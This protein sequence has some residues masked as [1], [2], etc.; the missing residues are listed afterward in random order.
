MTDL[1]TYVARVKQLSAAVC[2]AHDLPHLQRTASASAPEARSSLFRISEDGIPHPCQDDYSETLHLLEQKYGQYTA[3]FVAN[4]SS[5]THLSDSERHTLVGSGVAALVLLPLRCGERE[6]GLWQ[7]SWDEP[8]T[9]TT[10]DREMWHAY[11]SLLAPAFAY[12]CR[13]QTLQEI[14]AAHERDLDSHRGET[15]RLKALVET[16]SD[17][18]GYADLEG[19]VEYLNPASDQLLGITEDN[20][21]HFVHVSDIYSDASNAFF[22]Q[23][24]LPQLL[25][26]GTWR[27]EAT[28]RRADGSE[29]PVSQVITVIPDNNGEPAALGTVVR[30]I[31]ESKAL[32]A[33]LRRSNALHTRLGDLSQALNRVSNKRELL[34][35]IGQVAF[36]EAAT[37]VTLFDVDVQTMSDQRPDTLEAAVVLT[38]AGEN[39]EPSASQTI[40]LADFPAARL[41]LETPDDILLVSD[42]QT[43][44]RIDEA[45]RQLFAA[46]DSRAQ[47]I[48]PLL[49]N[50]QWMGVVGIAWNEPHD[51]LPREV[52]S[53]DALRNM[54]PP[55]LA[56]LNIVAD[57]ETLVAER[58]AELQA[59]NEQLELINWVSTRLKTTSSNGETLDILLEPLSKDAKASLWYV[60][61]DQKGRRLGAYLHASR[62]DIGVP[63]G[64]YVAD[65]DYPGAN[66][67]RDNPN[68]TIFIENTQT[69]TRV[70]EAS[71]D[72]FHKSDVA[73][74]AAIPLAE[75]QGW[76]G[77]LYVN[78]VLPRTF[79]QREQAYLAALP[80]IL[81][82]TLANRRLV[83]TLEETVDARTREL[84]QQLAKTERFK[85]LIESTTDAV[86]YADLDGTLHSLNVAGLAMFGDDA[87]EVYHNIAEMFVA[88]D[89]NFS[90]R[91]MPSL[92]EKG[93]WQGEVLAKRT[94]GSHLPT[95]EVV[96]VIRDPDGQPVALGAVIRDI[97]ASKA[98]EADLRQS[99]AT[100]RRIS[101]LSQAVNQV[102][103]K[104]QLHETITDTVRDIGATSVTLF[105]VDTLIT[106]G[107]P[108]SLSV[109][110]LWR[111]DGSNLLLVGTSF[112]L[113]DYPSASL[114]LEQPD[115]P[116]AV[117]DITTDPRLDDASKRTF[118]DFGTAAN[119]ILVLRQS[120]QWVGVLSIGWDE[121]HSYSDEENQLYDALQNIL[122][123]VLAN[124]NIVAD[125][126]N[127]VAERSAELSASN[128]QLA[129]INQV[130]SELKAANST[131]VMLDVLLEPLERSAS[132]SLFY[133]ITND[134]GDMQAIQIAAERTA[135]VAV[136]VGTVF[137]V[138]NYPV[139]Q[140]WLN[141]PNAAL[142]IEDLAHD[143]RIDEASRGAL[144]QFGAASAIV[145]LRQSGEWVGVLLISYRE[146]YTFSAQERAYFNALPT[147]L[148]P[149][150][151]NRRLVETLEETID[152]RTRELRQSRKL[153]LATIDNAP[154]IISVKD[155]DLRY[156]LANGN[157]DQLVPGSTPNSIIGKR[158]DAL[159][160]ADMAA[161]ITRSDEQVM[162]DKR[163]RTYQ[164]T[165]TNGRF[166]DVNKFPLLDKDGNVFAIGMVAS[167]I[168]EK[169]RKSVEMQ[170]YREQ[171]AK[172]ET[173]LHIT[174]RIQ[175]LLLPAGAELEDIHDLD[176]A[177]YVQ[178]AEQVGGDYYDVL[179]IGD[180][181]KIGIGDVTG[182]GLESGLL[183]LMTQT[184]VR[185]LMSTDEHDPVRIMNILNQTVFD[186]LQ[187]MN[188]NKSLTL[189]LLDYQ[190]GEAGGQLRV[191]GQHEHVLV[192]R[193]DGRVDVIDTLDLGMPLGLEADI[194]SFVAEEVIDLAIGEGVIL[195]TDG[196]TEAENDKREQFGLERLVTL[197]THHWQAPAQA[198]CDAVIS[199]VYDYIGD[200]EIYDDIT[201]LVF[202]RDAPLPLS[203]A[204]QPR[205]LAND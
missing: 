152:K 76:V 75:A 138:D 13:E 94:D 29:L 2:T 104:R 154:L 156:I 38:P 111:A 166:Y 69:D 188:T 158:D 130:S 21:A 60:K 55:A 15:L 83:E 26:T 39:T 196:I 191:S 23:H 195:F 201:L 163:T 73:A 51:F 115:V 98:L 161:D 117:S 186:N 177:C 32:E 59:S 36:D 61:N 67:H 11:A 22:E 109:A 66:L 79:S 45:S 203:S 118:A 171:L 9:L 31:S 90:D 187:R 96:T 62:P 112:P 200:H 144:Q 179:P 92:Q 198:I 119:T 143:T 193:N 132:A 6:V 86:A 142:L 136:P 25:Q 160:P 192:M 99:N 64:S 126:E 37:S 3:L 131:D 81:T 84:R 139:A 63:I 167:D 16:I 148:A 170:A 71:R 40:H 88:Q 184:A 150:L 56:N 105:D 4:S 149:P 205:P 35:L 89:E 162:R 28:L 202:K 108:T 53:Y 133:A 17:L 180:N 100:L 159:L 103:S 78:Y 58:S 93:V 54:V 95:S 123:P 19:N 124:L 129:L 122:P 113:A 87:L 50:D 65:A 181:V 91:I 146:A 101:K 172:A 116:F 141:N 46:I 175:E 57:L 174:R 194:S 173:E 42:S 47:A 134:Q 14:R 135:D 41:W 128:E 12:H 10:E 153:L 110:D 5:D 106:G 185:T 20:R 114:W 147:M 44:P 178:P 52:Q 48:I 80:A 7:L 97:S 49:Q 33:D 120:E 34:E 165:R 182:H 70:D 168:T 137:A 68:T 102:T 30:D 190:G 43:D 157:I 199:A 189:S 204:P 145:P 151:A 74:L 85:A 176:I 24:A 1:A 155:T 164:A 183:M 169:Q 77:M 140:L 121:I 197:A 125:L 127:L 27:G 18:V 72:M 82:P 107:V 8:Q